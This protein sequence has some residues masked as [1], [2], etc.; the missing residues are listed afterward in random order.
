MLWK[1]DIMMCGDVAQQFCQKVLRC[2]T[3][4]EEEEEAKL[5]TH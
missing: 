2:H 1:A 3:N 4:R 5:S